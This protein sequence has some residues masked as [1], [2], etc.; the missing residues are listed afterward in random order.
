MRSEAE[1]IPYDSADLTGRRVMVFA[2]HPDDE[3]IGCGGALALHRQEE[4]RMR[5]TS[6][7]CF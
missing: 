5:R 7:I 2:P 3:T 6:E 4:D 1:L